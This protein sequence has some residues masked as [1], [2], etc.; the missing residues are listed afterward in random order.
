MPTRAQIAAKKSALIITEEAKIIRKIE[1]IQGNIY[2]LILPD[3]VD[4]ANRKKNGRPYSLNTIFTKFKKAYASQFP[5]VMR[6]TYLAASGVTDLNQAYFGTMVSPASLKDIADKTR[7]AV[8]NRLG[9]SPSGKVIKNGF[10]DKVLGSKRAQND[11]VKTVNKLVASNADVNKMHNDIK[12]FIVGG[13]GSTGNLERYYRTTSQDIVMHIDRGNSLIYADELDLQH[14]MYGGGLITTSRSFCIDKS[15]K[16]FTRS[17]AQ[18]WKDTAFIK[19]M[20][21]GKPY[22]PIVDMGGYGCRHT[23]DWLTADVADELLRKRK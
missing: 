6:A 7:Q 4:V 12:A 5:E 21:G 16:I 20:Y 3:L 10:T 9:I 1:L 15:R 18:K 2:D 14:F 23:A 11:F 17:E 22:D 13:D 19:K 8:S